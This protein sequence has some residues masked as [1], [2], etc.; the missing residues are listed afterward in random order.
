[1]AGKDLK[2]TFYKL[3]QLD[4]ETQETIKLFRKIKHEMLKDCSQNEAGK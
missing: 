2:N 3:L 1:M 4:K